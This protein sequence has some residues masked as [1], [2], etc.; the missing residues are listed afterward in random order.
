MADIEL[1]IPLLTKDRKK[2]WKIDNRFLF[3]GKDG[4]YLRVR[5]KP[6]KDGR[7]DQYGNDGYCLQDVGAE[8]R[9]VLDKEGR[10]APLIGNW[11]LKEW[12]KKGGG[13][14]RKQ[15]EP[16]ATKANEDGDDVPF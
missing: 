7:K 14:P 2:L 1:F 10:K 11:R 12:D 5:A 6:T 4:W 15:A 3:E 13:A 16:E 9:E 8:G